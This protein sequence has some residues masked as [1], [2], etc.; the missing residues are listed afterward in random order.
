MIRAAVRADLSS[1]VPLLRELDEE[2]TRADPRYR[3]RPEATARMAETLSELWFDR[4]LPF[5]PCLV[6]EVDGVVAGV[7]SALPVPAHPILDDEATARIQHL[8][9]GPS[10]RRRGLAR[11][12][13]EKMLQQASQSGYPR[14]EVNTLALDARALGFWHSSGFRDLRMILAHQR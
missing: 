12:L 8:Y 13:V 9:V 7:I 5:P 2:G 3:V 1:V 6:A 11:A 10:F 14:V 4:F